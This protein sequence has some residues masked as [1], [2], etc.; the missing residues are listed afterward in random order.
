MISSFIQVK[1]DFF[2]DMLE[3]IKV[4]EYLPAIL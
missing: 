4:F 2:P 1:G 3:D